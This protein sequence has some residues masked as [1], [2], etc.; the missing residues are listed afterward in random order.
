[1]ND[2]LRLGNF[3][4]RYRTYIN[5]TT[6][7]TH[8]ID[9][10]RYEKTDKSRYSDPSTANDEYCFTIASFKR[11]N[12]DPEES[13]VVSCCNRLIESLETEDDIRI[14]KKLTRLGLDILIEEPTKI[15]IEES[16]KVKS[17]KYNQETG[18]LDYQGES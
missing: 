17:W 3:A 18:L 2:I 13:D 4:L 10:V 5:K 8:D 12:K 15:D 6:I 11:N 9:L 7:T 16:R 1:L 14:L